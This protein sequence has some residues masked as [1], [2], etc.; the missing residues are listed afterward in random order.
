MPLF[1]STTL[2]TWFLQAEISTPSEAS[3]ARPVGASHPGQCIVARRLARGNVDDRDFGGVFEIDEDAAA[4]VR[5]GG[6]RLAAQGDG[7][8]ARP[9][10]N[11]V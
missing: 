5:G 2:A 3:R 6:L 1:S 10:G 8:G 7:A 9:L 11:V 4:F